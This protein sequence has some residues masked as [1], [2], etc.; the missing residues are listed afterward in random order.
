VFLGSD[1][2]PFATRVAPTEDD[3]LPAAFA[4]VEPRRTF[5]ELR[6]RAEVR[7]NASLV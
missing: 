5:P 1:I 7:K 4:S 6:V 3:A 2:D